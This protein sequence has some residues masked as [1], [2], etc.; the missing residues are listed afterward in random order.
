MMFYIGEKR[1]YVWECRCGNMNKNELHV[2]VFLGNKHIKSVICP[3]CYREKP[4][5]IGRVL[6]KKVD[7]I[8]SGYSFLRSMINGDF[9]GDIKIQEIK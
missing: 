7:S 4:S 5:L 6:R 1:V 8:K 9:F 2:D 3:I